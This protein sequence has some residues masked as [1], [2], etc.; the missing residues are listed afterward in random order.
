[1]T[2]NADFEPKTNFIHFKTAAT[3]VEIQFL[4]TL[5]MFPSL[6]PQFGS[7]F[8]SSKEIEDPYNAYDDHM[9]HIFVHKM[10]VQVIGVW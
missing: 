8:F 9:I 4:S 2:L 3:E 6:L 10:N 7:A 1:M 5:I